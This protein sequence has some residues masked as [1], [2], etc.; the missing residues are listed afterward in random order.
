[1][2]RLL[3]IRTRPQLVVLLVK[4]KPREM[5]R[6]FATG[7]FNELWMGLDSPQPWL[8]ANGSSAIRRRPLPSS[9][10]YWLRHRPGI[11]C[12]IFQRNIPMSCATGL[13][14]RPNHNHGSVRL[15]RLRSGL[16]LLCDEQ[17][18]KDIFR[19]RIQF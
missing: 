3:T 11:N 10:Y 6:H 5:L 9:L 19:F 14:L 16:V 15:C 13:K 12:V 17:K 8:H 7:H 1:M 4:A 18:D 2:D